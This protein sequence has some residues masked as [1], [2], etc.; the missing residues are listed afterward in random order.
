MRDTDLLQLALGLSSPWRVTR[1]EFSNERGQ[2]DIYVDF[3]SGSRFTCSRRGR[4]G[5]SVHDTKPETWRHL[6]CF[7]HRAFLHARAPRVTC[8]TCGAGFTLLFEAYVLAL[9]KAVPVSNIARRVGE[10]DTRLWRI[11]EQIA[12]DET[13]ARNSGSFWKRTAATA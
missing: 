9:A 10:H 13:S 8:P 12:A 4:E 6:D 2:L 11:L 3:P 7:Q 5:C 1:A